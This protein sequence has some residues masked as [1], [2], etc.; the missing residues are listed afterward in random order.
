MVSPFPVNLVLSGIQGMDPPLELFIT[1]GETG[2]LRLDSLAGAGTNHL[3]TAGS[4]GAQLLG[5]S[6]PLPATHE[7]FVFDEPLELTESLLEVLLFACLDFLLIHEDR[8]VQ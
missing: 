2:H 7:H 5:D 1:G 8:L 6:R 3:V 4:G